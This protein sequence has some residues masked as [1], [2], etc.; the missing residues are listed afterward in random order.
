LVISSSGYI[1]RVGASSAVNPGKVIIQGNWT[2]PLTFSQGVV[3]FVHHSYNP[4]KCDVTMVPGGCHADTWHWSDFSIS[5]AVQYTLLRPTDHQVVTGSSGVVSFG[6]PAP[7]GSFLKFA[8]IGALQVSYDGGK[9]YHKP[10]MPPLDYSP[11]HEEHFANYMDPVPV[12]AT[13]ALFKLTGGWWG[14]A[15]ARDFS[16]ISQTLSGSPS[17]TP[18]NTPVPPTPTNTPVPPTPT[19]TPVPPTPTPTDTPTPEPTPT[20]TPG[21]PSPVPIDG[22]PCTV[23]L[24]NQPVSGTCSGTFTPYP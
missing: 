6:S 2:K 18:T 13:Q 4:T 21:G 23:I 20:G 10:A 12:G 24:D 17:P 1:F 9:T 11:L 14:G 19:A 7:S 22:V 5:N 3:Q 15:M 16:I 8:G